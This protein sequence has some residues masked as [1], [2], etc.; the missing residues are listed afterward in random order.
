MLIAAH[1]QGSL[2]PLSTAQALFAP[3]SGQRDVSSSGSEG[4]R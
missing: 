4:T 3:H 1:Q 2:E